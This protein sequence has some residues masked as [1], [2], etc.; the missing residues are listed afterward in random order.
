MRRLLIVVMVFVLT[1][2][3]V[4]AIAA[5]TP[6]TAWGA[7]SVLD[8]KVTISGA[9]YHCIRTARGNFAY[10]P[11][12][13]PSGS[14][15]PNS[16]QSGANPQPVD[17]KVDP[18]VLKAYNAYDHPA[19]KGSHPNFVATYLISPTYKAS[20]VSQQKGLFEQAMACYSSYFDKSVVIN[21]ALV[22][23]QDYDFLATQTTNGQPVFSDIQLRWAKFMMDRIK[24]GAGRFAGSAGWNVATNSAWVL[25]V[26]A[27]NSDVVDTHGAAHEFVHILQSYSK[28]VFFPLYG[29]G[30]ADADYVNMPPWFWEGTAELFSYNSISTS[31]GA[32]SAAMGQ[33]RQQGKDAPHLNKISTTAGVVAALQHIEAPSDQEANRMFYAIGP[34]ATEYLLATY[35]YSKYWK[36]MQSAGRYKDFNDNLNANIGLNQDQFFAKA[37]PFILSQW[38]LTTF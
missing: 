3:T 30:S 31:A 9:P 10:A 38:K 21:I 7:C 35:G 24:G 28:S 20:L 15:A 34:V 33:A 36:I 26:D 5:G 37:A 23:E 1:G 13:V 19:C 22:T 6:V 17:T 25:M 16:G 29:D 11:A 18:M 14:A 32:F 12:G 27:T 4:Q 2:T 8:K